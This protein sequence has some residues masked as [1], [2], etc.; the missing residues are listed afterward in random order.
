M[1]QNWL[2]DYMKFKGITPLGIVMYPFVAS[3]V[4]AL[5]VC[6]YTLKLTY[7]IR[8]KFKKKRS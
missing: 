5:L 1:G 3:I 6:M 7:W 4:G 8:K 2:E